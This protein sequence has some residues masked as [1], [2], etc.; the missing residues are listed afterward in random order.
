MT[1]AGRLLSGLSVGCV[2]RGYVPDQ[3]SEFFRATATS[4]GVRMEFFEELD[5]ALRWLGVGTRTLD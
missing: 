4:R 2:F 5:A 3:Q 1:S